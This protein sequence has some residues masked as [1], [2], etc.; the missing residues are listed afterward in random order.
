MFNAGAEEMRLLA[1]SLTGGAELGA[2]RDEVGAAEVG[3][4]QV[5][6]QAPDP[7]LRVEVWRAARELFEV[8]P[9]RG[10][11]AEELLH[12]PTAVDRRAVP[13]DE[14]RAGGVIHQMPQ[15]VDHLDAAYRVV[16]HPELE[17]RLQA[18]GADDGEVVVR[19]PVHEDRRLA[20]RH[21]GARDR[22]QEVE[23]ALIDEEDRAPLRQGLVF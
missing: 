17:L 15:E 22:R 8:N 16:V 18:D 20:Y 13:D 11:G 23:P 14:Q 7:F 3:Q 5:L 9:R 4:F 1:Q 2:Q 12:R 10:P 6:E 21:V 19:E